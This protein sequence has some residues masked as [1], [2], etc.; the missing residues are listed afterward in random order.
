MILFLIHLFGLC[1]KNIKPATLGQKKG[2]CIVP[3][4]TFAVPW[5]GSKNKGKEW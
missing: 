4:P 3:Y 1:I 2:L 5:E